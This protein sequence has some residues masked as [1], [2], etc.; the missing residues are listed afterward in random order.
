MTSTTSV[1][2]ALTSKAR[3]QLRGLNLLS[4]HGADPVVHALFAHMVTDSRLEARSWIVRY[5]AQ[6][7]YASRLGVHVT[8]IKRAIRT[9]E[10]IELLRRTAGKGA[11][12]S[13]YVLIEPQWE[14]RLAQ[15]PTGG[16]SIHA[17]TVGAST[18]GGGCIHAPTVGA[19]QA[20]IPIQEEPSNPRP[21]DHRIQRFLVSTGAAQ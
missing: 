17:P 1:Q 14:P 8:T 5:T 10:S 4:R 9:L 16:P 13:V 19:S 6:L 12:R 18:N 2:D 7:T 3:L 11:R 15:F 20:H 21:I